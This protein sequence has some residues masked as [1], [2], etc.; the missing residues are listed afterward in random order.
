VAHALALDPDDPASLADAAELYLSRLPASS[1]HSEI[2]LLYA[3][4]G[5]ERL[6]RQPKNRALLSRLALLEG[7]ALIDL[8]RSREALRRLDTA[9]SLNA[10]EDGKLEA[11]ARY[12]RAVALFELCELV[13]ARQ[14]FEKWLA[15]YAKSKDASQTAA[16]AHHHLGLTLEMLGAAGLAERELATAKRLQ[17]GAFPELLPVSAADFRRLVEDQAKA[18]SPEQVADLKRVSLE[19]AELPSLHDLT[20]EDPPLSPTILGLFRGQP[21]G[22]KPSEPRAIVLY[23]KNLLRAVHSREELV[24]EVRTTLLHELGHL[25]GADDNTLRERGLE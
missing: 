21:L 17:P 23:R 6:E 5:S 11:Q 4:R 7:Q 8:G 20:L 12:E 3:R 19:T 15:D 13:P 18:L 9:L 10:H 16:W 24:A 22:E 25:H 2:G 14:A 1:L